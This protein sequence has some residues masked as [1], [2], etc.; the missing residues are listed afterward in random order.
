MPSLGKRLA[1]KSLTAEQRGRIVDILAVADDKAAGAALLKV[2][3][4][5]APPEV[6][7]KI[8]DN[9]KLFLPNK[10]HDLRD[11]KELDESIEAAGQ[12]GNARHGPDLIAAAE[13]T[14]AA[15]TSGEDAPLT[16]GSGGRPR[17]GGADA[18]AL[19]SNDGAAALAKLLDDRAGGAHGGGSGTRQAGPAQ[20]E[21]QPGA[22]RR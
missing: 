22:A 19:P 5:D 15:R 4:T 14:D 6:R 11:S 13:K 12:A 1:D 18:G 9:L 10:W 16:Q 2:L 21:C 7:Q 8:I 17:R 3:E 20:G